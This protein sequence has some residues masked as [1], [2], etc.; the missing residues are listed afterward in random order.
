MYVY[1][2]HHE[3]EIASEVLPT[4]RIGAICFD[5]RRASAIGWALLKS[6]G[7]L[8]SGTI[9]IDRGAPSEAVGGLEALEKTLYRRAARELNKKLKNA[10][11]DR[12]N[13]TGEPQESRFYK[14][15]GIQPSWRW[16]GRRAFTL[17]DLLAIDLQPGL[18]L[19]PCLPN[20]DE[21]DPE[22]RARR[23]LEDYRLLRAFSYRCRAL[24]E[25]AA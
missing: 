24:R 7:E 1:V 21:P 18:G 20:R 19:R 11:V 8:T 10:I 16:A 23:D 17:I 25:E 9:E 5:A 3:G 12:Q 22:V 13:F 14:R 15:A 6:S 4:N 2:E